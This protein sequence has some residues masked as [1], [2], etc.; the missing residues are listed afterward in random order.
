M[1]KALIR[2]PETAVDVFKLLP[3]GVYC[4]VINNV[5]YMSPAPSFQHQHVIADIHFEI[6]SFLKTKNH[7]I[8]VAGPIDVYLDKHNAYQPD[9]LFVAKDNLAIIGTDGRVHGAPDLIIEVLS[10]S[11]E[12]D[13]RVKKKKVYE[14]CRVKEYF[15]V[16]PSTKEVISYYYNGSKFEKGAAQKGKIISKM[17]KKTFKF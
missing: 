5:I 10:P 14:K 8:C 13:D 7:G 6:M 3:E 16:A 15:I 11:S 12:G 1:K 17:L 9:I 2:R 4:Q